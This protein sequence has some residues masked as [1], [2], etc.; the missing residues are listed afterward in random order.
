[1]NCSKQGKGRRDWAHRRQA[2]LLHHLCGVAHCSSSP[3][4]SSTT[5]A[6]YYLV[7]PRHRH[8]REKE[9]AKNSKSFTVG[10][11]CKISLPKRY[12]LV[13][14]NHSSNKD[15]IAKPLSPGW[16]GRVA[17]ADR[18]C[19]NFAPSGKGFVWVHHTRKVFVWKCT[20]RTRLCTNGAITSK[21]NYH[22]STPSLIYRQIGRMVAST[23]LSAYGGRLSPAAASRTPYIYASSICFFHRLIC[24]F[25]WNYALE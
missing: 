8:Q 20:S 16:N 10:G 9:A 3:R 12:H 17:V 11:F 1:M 24:I 7:W 23:S 15:F 22:K 2:D 21:N 13:F 5:I 6:G 4:T 25:C 18:N 14:V 19:M